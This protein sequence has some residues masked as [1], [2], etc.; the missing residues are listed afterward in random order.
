MA[1]VTRNNAN[2]WR[3][4]PHYFG[5]KKNANIFDKNGRISLR[6]VIVII[7]LTPEAFL[8]KRK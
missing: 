8:P 7:T 1:F 2:F 5:L 4:F 6:I 3:K